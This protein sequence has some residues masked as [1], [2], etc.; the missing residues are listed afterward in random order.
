LTFSP[1]LAKNS[2]KLNHNHGSSMKSG[3]KR[4]NVSLLAIS[5]GAILG[6]SFSARA[7][8]V[9]LA[10]LNS[11]A[12]INTSSQQ[13]MFNWYVDGVTQLYQQWFWYGIGTGTGQS[14]IDTISA[15]TIN[16]INA[17]SASISYGNAQVSAQITYALTG[18]TLGSGNSALNESIHFVNV[19]ANSLTLRFYQYSDFDLM[20][21]PGGDSLQLYR[22]LSGKFY[23]AIQ[24]KGNVVMSETDVVPGANHGEASF[25]P[26]L[27]NRLNGGSQITLA[28][29]L[30]LVGPGDTAWAFE[31][32]VTLAAGASLDISK[33]KVISPVP[34]PG[35]LGLLGLGFLALVWRKRR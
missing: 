22:N 15:P 29:N 13:G 7:Q 10:D 9:T 19:S 3:F 25:Y 4:L 34:E 6:A 31:W 24:T 33:N 18:G 11:T 35:T 26:D 5:V 2:L 16:T 28:D 20:N 21:S 12:Q 23:E 30:G 14:S 32:D 1:D 27:L 17:S 8:I